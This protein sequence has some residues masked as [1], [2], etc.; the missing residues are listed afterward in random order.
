MTQHVGATRRSPSGARMVRR[1]A[2]C[3]LLT[4][5]ITSCGDTD[6]ELAE[7]CERRARVEIH[8]PD[9]WR[10][11]L[12]ELTAQRRARGGDP[13]QRTFASTADVRLM[14]RW[15]EENDP[16]PPMSRIYEDDYLVRQRATG[17]LIATVRNLSLMSRGFGAV[18]TSSCLYDYTAL[19]A[20]AWGIPSKD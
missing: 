20:K 15:A 12:A 18:R 13:D 7:V 2:G 4:L 8:R 14:S 10:A 11:Y 19:Y 5:F 3:I 1:L 6:A 17:A 16:M 9:A